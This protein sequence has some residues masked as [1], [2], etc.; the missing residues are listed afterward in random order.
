MSLQAT[1]DL[2]VHDTFNVLAADGLTKVTGL[3]QVTDMAVTVFR[4]GIV[5]TPF[6]VTIAEIGATGEYDILFTPD[7]IGNWEVHVETTTQTPDRRYEGRYQ[8][9]PVL[10]GAISG[11]VFHDKVTDV[12][13]NALAYVTV[14]V[15]EANTANLLATATTKHDGSYQINLTGALLGPIL[16]DIQFS[17]GGIQTFTKEDVNLS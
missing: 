10:N 17:G 7:Q 13:G 14:E 12:R 15:F 6:T 9:N 4:D 1:V 16:V 2:P 11:Q 3:T 8:V 5:V